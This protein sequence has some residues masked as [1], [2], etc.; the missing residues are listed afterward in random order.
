MDLEIPVYEQGYL[1]GLCGVYSIIN[2]TRLLVKNISEE[3]SMQLFK[4]CLTHVERKKSLSHVITD[5]ISRTELMS[6]LKDIV[7][8]DYPI[9]SKF[10]FRGVRNIGVQDFFGEIRAFLNEKGTR[11]VI[12]G[13]DCRDWD[14]WTVVKSV[15]PKRVTLFDSAMMKTINI[16]NCMLEKKTKAKQ[17][18]FSVN[19]T[20][21][22]LTK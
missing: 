6:I 10:P 21:F 13:F 11:A 7:T 19:E 14:H 1:D 5:G 17:Y 22:L 16:S 2:A 18:K 9:I 12:V 20:F 3:E 4:K 15:S 8:A